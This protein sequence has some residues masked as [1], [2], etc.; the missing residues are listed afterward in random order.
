M[1]DIHCLDCADGF[2]GTRTFQGEEG[3]D[4]GR[5]SQGGDAH[6]AGLALTDPG[7]KAGM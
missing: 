3:A 4:V 1:M 6:R 7:R 2:A 5:A